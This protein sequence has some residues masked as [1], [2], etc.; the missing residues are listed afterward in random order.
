[1]T[2]LVIAGLLL[3]PAAIGVADDAGGYPPPKTLGPVAGYGANVRRAMTLMAT[4]T[5]QKRNT[6]RVLFYGQSITASGTWPARVADDL[7]RRFPH[8]DL[9]IENRAIGGY[10]S[11]VLV[12]T[13]EA[14]LYPAYPDLVIFH[15]FGPHPEYEAIVRRLRERTTADVLHATDHL[16]LLHGD[17][18]DEAP[19]ASGLTPEQKTHRWQNRV[20]LPDLSRRYGTELADVRGLWR[21]YLKDHTLRV[22]DLLHD[23]VH[24]NAHGDYLLAE[25]VKAHLRHRPDLP[26]DGWEER[27]VTHAVGTDVRWQGG[28]LLLPFDGN[29]VDLLFRPG[30]GGS[31]AGVRI[32]GKR[33]SEFPELYLA[34]RAHTTN[35]PRLRP[36]VLRVQAAAPRVVEEWT[37]QITDI[38]RDRTAYKFRVAGSATGD[39]GA[40]ESGKRFVSKSG[41]VVLDPDDFHLA[42]PLSFHPDPN[43]TAVT[44]KWNVVPL[45]A[46]SAAAPPARGPGLEAAV[47]VAQGLRPGPHVLELTGGPDCP[48]EAVRVFRPPLWPTD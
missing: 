10:P 43:L 14:D 4:S 45:F 20:F 35:P 29:R 22:N 16:T 13:A 17:A 34:T 47:T 44:L 46:D 36:P 15:A 26:A 5:P 11:D 1:M 7:R 48:L 24:Q 32:D 6:I 9:H 21:Q 33:P 28:K 23:T 3:A 31:P 37:M 8:A 27:V 38:S 30:T 25:V 40:G 41:R 19:G 39:D 12:R 18:A 42:F 2:R